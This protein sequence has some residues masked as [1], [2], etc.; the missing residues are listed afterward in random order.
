MEV[1]FG[2]VTG[3]LEG[4]LVLFLPFWTLLIKSLGQGVAGLLG[5]P[6]QVADST[7]QQVAQ[8]SGTLSQTTEQAAFLRCLRLHETAD[9]TI[10]TA[11]AIERELESGVRGIILIIPCE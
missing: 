5:T 2:F 3:S 1:L 6:A 11:V 4:F 9:E 7:T 8:D 10:F